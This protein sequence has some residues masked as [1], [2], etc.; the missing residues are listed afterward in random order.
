MQGQVVHVARP[1]DRGTR[2]ILGND[3]QLALPRHRAEAGG[4]TRITG[5]NAQPT[6]QRAE[7]TVHQLE[8]AGPEQQEA[9]IGTPAQHLSRDQ[10]V[11]AAHRFRLLCRGQ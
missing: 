2:G 8:V 3:Q 7:L 4:C 6:R 5:E 1:Q 9:V 10:R 11:V